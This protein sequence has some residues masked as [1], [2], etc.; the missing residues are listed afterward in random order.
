MDIDANLLAQFLDALKIPHVAVLFGMLGVLAVFGW[1]FISYIKI[2]AIG[3]THRRHGVA[4][5][6]TRDRV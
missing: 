4:D 1:I 5:C 6:S 2:S 3:Q